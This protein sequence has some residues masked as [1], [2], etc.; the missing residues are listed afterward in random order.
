[1]CDVV[2]FRYVE[3][4]T[5]AAVINACKSSSLTICGKK[6]KAVPWKVCHAMLCYAMLVELYFLFPLLLSKEIITYWIM[7]TSRSLHIIIASHQVMAVEGF[8]A[9]H[10]LFQAKLRYL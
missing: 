2:T 3:F 1:M 7:R 5:E 8:L 10:T 9:P 6:V 4:T